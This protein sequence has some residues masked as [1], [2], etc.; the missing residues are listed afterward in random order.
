VS[1]L[2]S[3]EGVRLEINYTVSYISRGKALAYFIPSWLG[4]FGL[5]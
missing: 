1:I 4:F 5:I 2:L 3:K